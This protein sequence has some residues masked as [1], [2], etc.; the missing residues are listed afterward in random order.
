MEAVMK[1]KVLCLLIALPL[2]LVMRVLVAQDFDKRLFGKWQGTGVFNVLKLDLSSKGNYTIVRDNKTVKSGRYKASA[3]KIL[4]YTE[5][6]TESDESGF[7]EL[8]G[9]D[10]LTVETDLSGK[11]QWLRLTG[12]APGTYGDR[13]SE[14]QRQTGIF[15]VES[16]EDT[17]KFRNGGS[18]ETA[19]GSDAALQR[20]QAM[21]RLIGSNPFMTLSK[22]ML[23]LQSPK[24][25]RQGRTLLEA[26][27]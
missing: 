24:L 26:R 7:Y 9:M 15:A 5:T 27:N 25:R 4:F 21:T 11:V 23:K 16:P 18:S 12:I 8:K 22:N 1:Q 20:D 10:Q 19:G 2:M 3:G 17:E 6:G 13:S 14:K